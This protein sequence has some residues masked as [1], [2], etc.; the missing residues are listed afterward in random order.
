MHGGFNLQQFDRLHITQKIRR[1]ATIDSLHT[2][3]K[4]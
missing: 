4:P 2:K 1:R 3:S